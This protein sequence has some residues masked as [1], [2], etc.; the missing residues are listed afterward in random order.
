M[1]LSEDKRDEKL[2]EFRSAFPLPRMPKLDDPS[3]WACIT[4][5]L[6][7]DAPEVFGY[8]VMMYKSSYGKSAG[9]N[10][11]ELGG[12]AL[13]SWEVRGSVDGVNFEKLHT[14]DSFKMWGGADGKE[15]KYW[16]YDQRNAKYY[17]YSREGGKFYHFSHT[18]SLNGSAGA[19]LE[20][21]ESISVAP[22][23]VLEVHGAKL[24]IDTLK[25]GA[26]GAG[27]FK[28][29][30]FAESGKIDIAWNGERSQ[31]FSAN[32]VNAQNAANIS[33]WE[34]T[35]NGEKDAAGRIDVRDGYIAYRRSGFAVLLR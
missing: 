27:T 2:G 35:I 12:R 23:A 18:R 11:E 29:V 22:G 28:N 32:F 19:A 3:T 24:E 5:R 33:K 17:A 13:V 6:P 9:T 15:T 30:K 26:D 25:I 21:V 4:L 1:F 34:I 20:N 8:D 10:F 14:V 7:D 16:A 31:V